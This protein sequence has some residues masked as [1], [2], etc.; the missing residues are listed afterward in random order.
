MVINSTST[1]AINIQAVSP[2]FISCA[3]KAVGLSAASAATSVPERFQIE[4]G[5]LFHSI[6]W[7]CI[8]ALLKL[9]SEFAGLNGIVAGFTR[10]D[11]DGLFNVVN[12]NL[13]VTDLAR[14][15]SLR[16]RF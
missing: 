1:V 5:I 9:R 11:T 2:E 13:A 6:D 4:V 3:N 12:E 8:Q 14:V 7:F 10:A 16:N 15:G